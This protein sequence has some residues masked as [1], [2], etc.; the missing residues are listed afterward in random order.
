MAC[1]AIFV[2]L[3]YKTTGFGAPLKLLGKQSLML[4]EV[5]NFFFLFHVIYYG[6]VY[7]YATHT[8]A[9]YT[10]VLSIPIYYL[11]CTYHH[12]ASD[13]ALLFY[14]RARQLWVTV[15]FHNRMLLSPCLTR[16]FKI[17][18]TFCQKQTDP[19][20]DSGLQPTVPNLRLVMIHASIKK[21]TGVP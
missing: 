3:G 20:T 4:W 7:A 19:N 8:I 12:I 16:S 9:Y 15:L 11:V 6:H 5:I 17:G 2:H 10:L 1:G 21:C 13:P 18:N 14:C